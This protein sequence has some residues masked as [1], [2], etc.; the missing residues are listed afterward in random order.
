MESEITP[1][2]SVLIRTYNSART[3][4]QV[5]QK[6]ILEDKDEL[7]V[8]DS[9]STDSTIEVAQSYGAHVFAT[10]PPFNYSTSLNLGFEVAKNA[11][12]LVISSHTIPN[13]ADIIAILRDF[14]VKAPPDIVVGF[15]VVG[16]T[17]P[18][19]SDNNTLEPFKRIPKGTLSCG[20]GNTLALYRRQIWLQHTFD[21]NLATAEDLEWFI[22]AVQQGYAGAQIPRAVATYRN[23]GS[24]LHMFRKGWLE[25]KQA[26]NLTPS[27]EESK[28]EVIVHCAR[29]IGHFSKLWILEGLPFISMLKQQSHHIGSCLAKLW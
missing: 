26:Q 7:I 15:G 20:A 13:A 16:L 10:Q 3:L 18:R 5:L 28:A 9:G 24:F 11:W 21:E 4:P 27:R 17:S 23:Q 22:W 14:A 19:H 2:I 6:L 1:G 8:I 25:V 12:I 29:G